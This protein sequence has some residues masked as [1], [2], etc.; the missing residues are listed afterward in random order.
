EHLYTRIPARRLCFSGRLSCC[1]LRSTVK[2]T[3]YYDVLGVNVEAS[4]AEIKKAYYVKVIKAFRF[5]NFFIFCSHRSS[6]NL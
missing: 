1:D 5:P 6:F 3:T 4:Y 2:D